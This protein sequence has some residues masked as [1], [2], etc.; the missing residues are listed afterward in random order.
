MLLD[1]RY[2]DG[3]NCGW[4]GPTETEEDVKAPAGD[5]YCDSRTSVGLDQ[6]ETSTSAEPQTAQVSPSL[7]FLSLFISCGQMGFLAVI[8]VF[9]FNTTAVSEVS[10][11]G[12]IRVNLVWERWWLVQDVLHIC[13]ANSTMSKNFASVE[14]RNFHL[15]GR[16]GFRVEMFIFDK[17][18][19]LYFKNTYKRPHF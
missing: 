9:I 15:M 1:C 10:K 4:N 11:K 13:M 12:W 2:Q 17:A 18:D 7:C 6:G 16:T 14:R 8:H 5:C 3:D 19:E